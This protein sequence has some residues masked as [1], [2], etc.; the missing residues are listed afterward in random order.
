MLRVV[1]VVAAILASGCAGPRSDEAVYVDPSGPARPTAPAADRPAPSTPTTAATTTAEPRSLTLV[2]TGDLLLHNRV[3]RLAAQH[4]SSD[5]DRDYDF[6]PLLEPV[7]HL[8]EG[9]D[10]AICHLE[11]SLSADDTRLEPYPTFRS[12]GQIADDARDLGYD[13]CSVA[14]NHVLDHGP[15]GVA[16]TLAVLDRAGIR[17]TG[18]ARSA[19]EAAEQIWI[20]AGPFRVAHLSYSY[21]FNGFSIPADMPWLTNVIDEEQILLDATRARAGGADFVVLSLHWGDQYRVEPNRQQREIGPRLLSSPDVDLIIGHHAHV[22]QPID[23]SDGEWLVHGLGNLVAN[24]P[25]PDRR[26][27]LLVQVTIV[28]QPDG[29]LDSSLRAVPLHVDRETL[30][31]HPS[32]PE[33]RPPDIGPVLAAELDRS[34]ARVRAVLE[35]GSAWEHLTVG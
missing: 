1:L 18:A 7:R 8:I 32:N 4:A 14:S 16:D 5:K 23:E 2:F 10:S 22:V 35:R 19:E 20:D 11:V 21:G 27:E 33:A 17:S 34:W 9:A 12:P 25:Q 31:V 3:N 28:E 29:S 30:T 26:D 24:A 15:A 13:S 6:R